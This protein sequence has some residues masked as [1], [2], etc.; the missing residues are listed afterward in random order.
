M[1]SLIWAPNAV[2]LVCTVLY[3]VLLKYKGVAKIHILRNQNSLTF[4]L[5]LMMRSTLL[6]IT[7]TLLLPACWALFCGD[8]LIEC[9]RYVNFLFPARFHFR[10]HRFYGFAAGDNEAAIEELLEL[11][12]RDRE[13]NDDAAKQ[14]LFKIFDAL[15]PKDPLALSGRR[16]LSSM[17]FA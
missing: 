14:Q 11:F 3:Y 2:K 1:I 9:A 6:I 7:L 13:W 16:R 17:I 15:G 8:S 4:Q 10:Y 5:E 12:R